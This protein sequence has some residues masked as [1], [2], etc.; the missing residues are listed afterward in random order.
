MKVLVI[1][2]GG[3]EHVSLSL[4]IAAVDRGQAS[5]EDDRREGYHSVDRI[6]GFD[7]I[8]RVRKAYR[9]HSEH[10]HKPDNRKQRN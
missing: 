8:K 3:R 9:D 2:N 5:E 6:R 4:E 7:E 10:T 1:G